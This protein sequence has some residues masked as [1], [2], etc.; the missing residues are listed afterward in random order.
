MGKLTIS[1]TLTKDINYVTVE[2]ALNALYCFCCLVVV[3]FDHSVLVIWYFIMKST[4]NKWYIVTFKYPSDGHS[5]HEVNITT[6]QEHF[7]ILNWCDGRAFDLISVL[8]VHEI[9]ILAFLLKSVLRHY[10]QMNIW[11]TSAVKQRQLS[12]MLDEW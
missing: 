10:R 2:A 1:S 6:F 5:C 7:G 8:F 12:K 3:V 9:S 11:G 4:A